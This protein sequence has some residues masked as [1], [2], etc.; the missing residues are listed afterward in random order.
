MRRLSL[1]VGLSSVAGG[2]LCLTLPV[3]AEMYARVKRVYQSLTNSA[4][5]KVWIVVRA[6][7]P[8]ISA[9]KIH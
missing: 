1:L 8:Q 9:F 6:Y 5:L 3:Q 4:T 2:L 7:P